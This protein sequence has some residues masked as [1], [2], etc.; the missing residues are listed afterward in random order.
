MAEVL[1]IGLDI[2]RLRN[3]IAEFTRPEPELAILYSKSSIIQV[4]PQL[5]R[6]GRTPY[7]D[8]VFSTWEGARYL[9]CRLG[10]VSEKQVLAGKLARFKLLIVPAA[11]YSRDDVVDGVL[12][13]VNNGGVAV[14]A[15][16]SFLFDEYAREN[17]RVTGLGLKVTDITLPQVLGEG[18]LVQNYD[19]SFTQTIVY[20]DVKRTVRTER[21]D[22]F[23][24][25]QPSLETKGLVQSLDAGKNAVLAR[26]DNGKP[27]VVL[28]K[29]GKGLIYYLASPLVSQ[30]YHEFLSPLAE[31]LGLKRPV[32]AV[33]N[34][35]KL[36]TGVEV[37][38]VERKSDYLVYASN[39]GGE[40]VEFTLKGEKE[41]GT[42]EDL[43][44]L[45]VVPGG[46][47]KLGP[48]GETIF[49]VKKSL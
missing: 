48:W 36:I 38:S 26:F 29:R 40:A 43:R 1:R 14:I 39:L 18:E 6:A 15:P 30:S 37:R 42:V 23:E 9:G 25:N 7:L 32:V 4:P 13:Y 2:R 44:S 35:G 49:K 31:Q 10:F 24:K 27:A 19:Q 45:R 34:D 12:E 17:D 47:V 28:V 22:I 46:R 11:K 21:A 33:D 5:I 41:I 3:E 20:G 16:E 8:A